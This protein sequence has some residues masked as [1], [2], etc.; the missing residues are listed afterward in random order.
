MKYAQRIVENILHTGRTEGVNPLAAIEK[1]GLQHLRNDK[2]KFLKK[3]ELLPEQIKKV[4]GYK[5]DLRNQVANTAMEMVS[6]ITT[7][8]Q[9][10]KIAKYLLDKKH[11]FKTEAEAINYIVGAKKVFKIPRLGVLPSDIIGLY[12][13]PQTKRMLEGVGGTLDKLIDIA[14]WRHALQFKVLTQMGKTV[15]SPQTQVRNVEASALFPMVN[16]HIGGRASVIDSMKI[17]WRDIFPQPGKVNMKNFYDAVE[18]EVRLGTMDENVIQQEIIA[19]TQDIMKGSVNTLDKLFQRLQD[20]VFVKNASRVYAGGDNMWK[21]YGRQ[22][23]KSQLSAVFPDRKALTDYMKYMGQTVNEDD[24]LTGAK[25]TF[26]DLL[27]DASAWEIRNTYPTYSK[28]PQFIQDIRK[29]P[30]FG[31]FVSFQAEILRT[32]TNIMNFG[33]RQAAHKDPRIRQMGMRRLMA[34]SLGFYGYGAGIYNAALAL[35]K[36]ASIGFCN[37]S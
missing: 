12:V 3:G 29:I 13:S 6:E 23:A 27:D 9:Y 2:F 4:L 17:V 24:L 7:K 22:W 31:N 20:T 1:I 5:T 33:L 28:V 34:A 21:W 30:F 19:V 15:F 16:G 37:T 10:D 18:K 8:K 14:I 26:D 11:A 25:K 35:I 36:A 32:G